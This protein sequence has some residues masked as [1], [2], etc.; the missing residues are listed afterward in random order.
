MTNEELRR[1]PEACKAAA[2]AT[3]AEAE[4][5]ARRNPVTVPTINIEEH[6]PDL[7][8]PI[9]TH[10]EKNPPEESNNLILS[11]SA[12]SEQISSSLTGHYQ[13]PSISPIASIA[14]YY[15]PTI[16]DTLGSVP[17]PLSPTPSAFCVA[18][19]SGPVTPEW[20]PDGQ[21]TAGL[22][23]LADDPL[24]LGDTLVAQKTSVMILEPRVSVKSTAMS[25]IEGINRLVK[26][27]LA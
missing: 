17:H 13:I 15:N 20:N 21:A 22:A 1:A 10:N 5:V 7:N 24:A 18:E 3:W 23:N 11:S 2:R 27:R 25:S 12:G 26:F 16:A 14:P 9:V 4:K 19:S 6:S 8:R